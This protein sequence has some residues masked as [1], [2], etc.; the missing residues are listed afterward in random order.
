VPLISVPRRSPRWNLTLMPTL[1]YL[2]E[3]L[4]SYKI[5]TDL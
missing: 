3:E 2:V 5:M 1:V 4:W